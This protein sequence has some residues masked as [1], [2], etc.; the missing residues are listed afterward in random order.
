VALAAAEQ[1]RIGTTVAGRYRLVRV[2][3]RGGMGIVYEAEH[4]VTGRH[5]A[6]KVMHPESEIGPENVKRFMNEA[7]AAGQ[8]KHPNVVAVLDAGEDPDDGSLFIVLEL[9]TG[10][11]LA[12]YLM[13]Y[14][15]LLPTEAITVVSQVLQA[16]IAAH[17]EGIVHRD[18]K[19]ENIFL[20]RQ[21]S[22]ET[23][24][25]IVDFGISKA[26]NPEKSIPLSITQSNTT[27]GTPHYMSPE[28]ARG[29]AIDPR[30]D[31]WALGVVMYECLTGQL[32]F[33]GD[34]YNN[35]ILAV[36]T[37]AHEQAAS[38]GVEH[39]LSD[40][41]DRCLQKDREDRYESAAAMLE[42]LREYA[43]T[44]QHL[45]VRASLLKGPSAPK[46]AR[47][48]PTMEIDSVEDVSDAE[49]DTILSKDTLSELPVFPGMVSLEEEARREALTPL[50]RPVVMGGAAPLPLSQRPGAW[51]SDAPPPATPAEVPLPEIPRAPRMPSIDLTEPPPAPTPPP[52]RRLIAVAFAAGVA[53][54][55]A[56]SAA[57][58]RMH[59]PRPTAPVPPAQV[60]IRFANLP[61]QAQLLLQGVRY[62]S[63][64]AYV[65]RG[66]VS[67]PVRI[68][69]PGF[70]PLEFQLV[71][72]RDQTVPVAM[73]RSA[74]PTP[75]PAP[76]APAPT[77]AAPTAR[78]PEPA[79]TPPSTNARALPPL[80][81]SV[82]SLPS[83]AP[84]TLSIGGVPR[85]EVRIDEQPVGGT[86]IYNRS[87]A[88]GTHRIVCT[89]AGVHGAA[90]RTHTVTVT[91]GQ[92]AQLFCDTR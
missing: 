22:G 82:G 19:P 12:T 28:Q 77:P 55:L 35:Q 3:G 44:H 2:L 25:K 23:H 85:W 89:R 21:S 86:P 61:D 31:I 58:V 27:V 15:K 66:A 4:L 29:D 32:P 70:E 60:Q 56:V 69:A 83:D 53:L 34:N 52:R 47:P 20:A 76:V 51:Q 7:N 16:L 90:L 64:T 5:V 84:A 9:L 49:L 62:W 75:P 17:R 54:S 26:I 92:R 46:R 57:A 39:G 91:A 80:P 67:L 24:V 72:D 73:Q 79:V 88:A 11:D 43:E 42:A 45:G 65:P 1:V 63:D 36:V 33:D 30:S 6:I 78:A 87:I 38:L 40:I 50:A 18:L 10:I 74:A 59:R 8:V 68:E 48:D 37:E 13:R 81:T 71:P 14:E 41:I